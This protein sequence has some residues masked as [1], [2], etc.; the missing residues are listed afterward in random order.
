MH[1]PYLTTNSHLVWYSDLILQWDISR[2]S[3]VLQVGRRR[4]LDL[5]CLFRDDVITIP[6][7]WLCSSCGNQWVRTRSSE[8]KTIMIH[9]ASE[10][11][12]PSSTG[13]SRASLSMSFTDQ[14]DSSFSFC[15]LHFRLSHWPFKFYF[16]IFKKIPL[17]MSMSSNEWFLLDLFGFSLRKQTCIAHIAKNWGVEYH[18][19]TCFNWH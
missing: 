14:T 11:T 17:G 19:W 10:T 4:L 15:T 1:G 7:L 12:G 8:E 5:F 16:V 13:L 2:Q 18:F 9:Q 6:L 3:Q